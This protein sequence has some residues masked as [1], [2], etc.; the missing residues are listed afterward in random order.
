MAGSAR[1]R[2]QSLGGRVRT[3]SLAA[4]GRAGG[5][6][7]GTGDRVRQARRALAPVQYRRGRR[8]P[9]RGA[10]GARPLARRARPPHGSSKNAICVRGVVSDAESRQ[11]VQGDGIW[12]RD[13]AESASAA[14]PR[15]AGTATPKE[16][17]TGSPKGRPAGPTGDTSHPAHQGR[18]GCIRRA[19][20]DAAFS[21]ILE[22]FRSCSRRRRGRLGPL[23][24]KEASCSG[25]FL[26]RC[27][28]SGPPRGGRLRARWARAGVVLGVGIGAIGSAYADPSVVLP[29]GL[30]V[31]VHPTFPEPGLPAFSFPTGGSSSVGESTR[32]GIRAEEAGARQAAAAARAGAATPII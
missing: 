28:A 14:L 7:G 30:P 29:N 15:L 17:A 4:Q 21:S 32:V 9:H 1:G 5:T 18:E 6:W 10:A 27:R 20:P 22:T 25:V 19:H 26:G 31:Q 13:G 16:P 2:R 11:D 23:F 8:R 24:W 12:Q 3:A